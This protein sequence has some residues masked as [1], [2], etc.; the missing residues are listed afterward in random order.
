MTKS[1]KSAG[2]CPQCGKETVQKYR[3]FCSIRCQQLDLG[4]WF[5]ESYVIPGEEALSTNDNEDD[6]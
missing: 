3:P 4:K 1:T 2:K 5:N 6:Y